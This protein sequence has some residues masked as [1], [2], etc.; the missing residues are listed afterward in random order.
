[1]SKRIIEKLLNGD[2]PV[3]FNWNIDLHPDV[4]PLKICP[5]EPSVQQ[6]EK[7]ELVSEDL[8]DGLHGIPE[9]PTVEGMIQYLALLYELGVR[10]FTVGIYPGEANKIDASIKS[11]LSIM[12][13]KYT[14]ATPI[15]LT[16]ASETGLSWIADCKKINPK[17]NAIIFMGTAPSRLL[18]EEWNKSYILERLGWAVRE[19]TQKYHIN[20]IGATE[21]TT[22]TPPDFLRDIIKTVVTSGAK[23]FC[24]ADTIGMARPTG[25]ARIVNYTRHILDI[26]H[27]KDVIIDWHG[28]DDLGNGQANAM[29]AIACGA[30]RIHTVARGIGER[31]G[32]TRMESVLL[33]CVEILKEQNTPIPWNM[34][35]LHT[36][37][38]TY[39]T[40]TQNP[41]PTHG[42]LGTR[43]FSTS[44]GIHT[45]AMLKAKI[46]VYTARRM[47]QK[48]LA[49]KLEHMSQR[50]YSALDPHDVGRKHEIHVGP[51][52]GKSTIQLAYM[53]LGN[54]PKELTE[55]LILMVL[56][57][58]KRLGRELTKEELVKLLNHTNSTQESS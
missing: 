11:V 30:K 19:A 53:E 12:H 43:S 50:I 36:I 13:K 47:K 2:L 26:L 17:L 56:T 45:A 33:N 29:T 55:E 54:D 41:S 20:V 8:R 31:A 10:N 39:D 4:P 57:T 28:H 52:S 38:S 37:L 18:V 9:Y 58:V 24:I 32:N 23:Y 35:K 3:D 1:M 5:L 6:I 14:K 16:L 40:L 44:L 46:L 22:Q 15:V 42:P 51:W 49:V 21:H 34:K 25:V 27:A 48:N 7:I